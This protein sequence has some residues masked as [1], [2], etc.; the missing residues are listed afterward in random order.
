MSSQYGEFKPTNGW[1]RLTSLGYPSKFQRVSR[2]GFVTALTSLNG[3]QPNFAWCLAVSWDGTLYIHFR[4]LLRFNGILP[5]AKFTGK[6]HFASKS[7]ILLYWQRYCTALEQWQD[8]QH[9]GHQPT[10]R[11]YLIKDWLI[12]VPMT[13]STQCRSFQRHSFQPIIQ[14]ATEE[15]KPNT[16]KADMNH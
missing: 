8:G 6:I 5:G 13:N 7:C 14:H 2:L 12:K 15:S 9:V 3:S 4:R 10:S 11:C 1:H 16:T